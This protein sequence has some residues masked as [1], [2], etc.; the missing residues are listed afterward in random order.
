MKGGGGGSSKEK[1]QRK[2][3]AIYIHFYTDFSRVGKRVEAGTAAWSATRVQ[4]PHDHSGWP[5]GDRNTH[6]GDSRQEEVQI[7]TCSYPRVL[8]AEKQKVHALVSST[9]HTKMK[10][11]ARTKN[12]NNAQHQNND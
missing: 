3:Y 10:Q 7:L 6:R 12:T 5:Q 8:P 1:T 2:F 9:G 11:R 4:C